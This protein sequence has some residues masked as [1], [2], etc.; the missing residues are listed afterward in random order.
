MAK[1]TIIFWRDIPSQV[2]VK[3]GRTK[4]KSQ[5]SKRFMVAIDRAAMRAGRQGSA[6]YLED[7]RREIKTCQGDPQ[8]IA[9]TT[10][11]EMEDFYSDEV[12]QTLVKNKGLK[13]SD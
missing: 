7:W 6:E 11:K 8:T 10:A 3:E 13:T 1:K 2:V 5:L 4:A 12:L 9:E